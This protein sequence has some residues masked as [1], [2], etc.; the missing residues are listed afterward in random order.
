VTTDQ[1]GRLT[2]AL[3]DRYRI[4]RE[5]GQGGMATVY[6]A[7]DLRHGRD[8]A[9]KVL[10]PDLAAALGG[11]RFLSEI[12]TTAKLQH[13]HI[14]P[15]LDSGSAEGLLYYV[16]PYMTGETLR[17][18]LERERQLPIEDAL[19]IT[20]EVADALGAAHGLGIIHRD[21]KP[22]NILLQGGHAL[23]ADFGIALAVQQAGG[24]RMT[25]TGLSLGTPQYMSPEQAMGERSVDARS[26][27]YALGAVTYEMLTGDPPFTGS[28]VQAIVAKVLSEKPTPIHTLRETVPA[29]VE[30]AVFIA[31]A[32]LPADRFT[33]VKEFANA[34]RA[35]GTARVTTEPGAVTRRPSRGALLL[36]GIVLAALLIALGWILGRRRTGS[37][38]LA[39]GTATRFVLEARPGERTP[40]IIGKVFALSPDGSTLVYVASP[41]GAPQRLYRRRFDELEAAP[42]PGTTGATDPVFSPDGHWIAFFT[43]AQLVKLPLEGGTPIRLASVPGATSRGVA[44]SGNGEVVFA[45]NASST[46]F[47]VGQDGGAIREVFHAPG[48]DGLRWPVAIPGSDLLLFASFSPAGDSVFGYAGSLKDGTATRVNNDAYHPL[49]VLDGKLIYCTRTGDVMAA[50]F[51]PRSRTTTG[52]PR[53]VASDVQMITGTGMGFAALSAAGDLVF[54]DGTTASQLLYADAQGRTRL[55]IPDTLGFEN[56]RFSPDGRSIAMS[57]AS[58][59]RKS[60]WILD[61]ASGILSRLGEEEVGTTRDRPEWSPDGRRLFYRRNSPTGNGMVMRSADRRDAEALIPG[62]RVAINELVMA[63]DGRTVLG[64][65]SS[66]AASSQDLWA[67]TLP[68]TVPLHFTEGP[69]FET[70]PRFSPDGRWVA[71]TA[72]TSGLREVYVSPFPGPGGRIQVSR[73]GAGLPIWG[74]DGRTIYYPQGNR[75]IAT[76]LSFTPTVTVTG[77]RTLFEGDYA[78]DDALHAPFDVAPDGTFLLVR[79]V[80]EVRTVI[81]RDFRTEMRNQLVK[82]GVR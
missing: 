44:W 49:G 46:L 60:I 48:I 82:Q 12:K 73:D 37:A 3:A 8:V 75:M 57:I 77:T 81:I 79:P 27:I 76:T 14:L 33:T 54:R 2:T 53:R 66:G 10:H 31:L 40:V 56:P 34:L 39:S 6:L 36:A 16:M 24:Q 30:Q 58:F 52:T 18:R 28:T 13:P 70:G 35:D 55:A 61:R 26:D 72:A 5:L 80:R 65:A 69:E 47:A 67:W 50:P 19:L 74:H 59:N 64:R 20:R 38:E 43:G 41:Q 45:T 15:L 25:Q 9:I 62:P 21:I 11:E 51:D 29:H 32:K 71:F 7:H 68:D 23:V 78:L 63:P 17:A 22:E 4:E 1:T 42:I